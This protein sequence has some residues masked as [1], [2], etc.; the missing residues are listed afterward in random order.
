MAIRWM[1]SWPEMGWMPRSRQRALISGGSA[2]DRSATT[3]VS[4][5]DRLHV[6]RRPDDVNEHH[7]G[8]L[9]PARVEDTHVTRQPSTRLGE[10]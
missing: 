6:P 3:S 4:R 9:G 1:G 5:R 8:M 10:K 2:P 7:G